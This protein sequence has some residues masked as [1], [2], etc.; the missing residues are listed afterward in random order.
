[1]MGVRHVG[2]DDFGRVAGSSATSVDAS[3]ASSPGSNGTG[4]VLG[5][6]AFVNVYGSERGGGMGEDRHWNENERH[7]N[8]DA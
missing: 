3:R 8:E 6:S 1:M 2:E 5:G 7:W 4:H